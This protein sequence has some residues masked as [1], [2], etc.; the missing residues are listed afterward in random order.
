M[1]HVQ[2]KLFL[3]S[4][5]HIDEKIYK[6][7][8]SKVQNLIKKTRN[9]SEMNLK[10]KI[11]KPKELW[12]IWKSVGLPPKAA[13]ALNISLKGKNE[14]VF[15]DTKNCSIFKSFYSNLEQKFNYD[16]IKFKDLNF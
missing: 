13:S 9:F 7:V 16:N 2:Q 10:Q 4:K 5:F 6:K 1:V 15:N 14:I 8:K 3:K 12:K 11:N